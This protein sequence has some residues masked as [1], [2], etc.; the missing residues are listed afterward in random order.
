MVYLQ[1][2]KSGQLPADL[3]IPDDAVAAESVPAKD[4]KMD[5][6]SHNDSNDEPKNAENKQQSDEAAPIEQVPLS[7][8]G[9]LVVLPCYMLHITWCF[10]CASDNIRLTSMKV[11]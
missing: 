3:K 1:A 4:D 5:L 2:L 11:K 6:D 8:L 10:V 9:T 7:C